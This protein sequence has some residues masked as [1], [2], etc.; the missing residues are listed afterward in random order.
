MGFRSGLLV[1]FYICIMP[2]GQ[3]SGP[4][5]RITER[6]RIYRTHRV[7]LRVSNP[8]KLIHCAVVSVCI[9]IARP[10]SVAGGLAG[11]NIIRYADSI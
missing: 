6:I 1:S 4:Y 8:F 11:S 5:P 3:L 10:A 7:Y 2:L 9:I